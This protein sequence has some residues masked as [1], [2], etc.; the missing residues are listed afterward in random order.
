VFYYY[1]VDKAKTLPATARTLTAEQC[2]EGLR[3]A[4]TYL[5]QHFG[6]TNVRLGEYQQHVRGGKELPLW[7]LPDVMSAI[8][9]TPYKT[10]AGETGRVHS[11]QGES[12]I[13]LAKFSPSALPEIETVNC[14]GASANPDS[15]HYTD[16]MKL[17][18]DMKTKPMTLDK[19][20]VLRDARRIY[21][22]GEQP[23][24]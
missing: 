1:W 22:P 16:Q 17:Y 21:H 3:F 12:Y 18:R 14:F 2:A 8:S 7:G 9:S 10:A 20:A 11:T 4:K 15:P 19:A 24:K 5:Q 6:R 23:T 13:M